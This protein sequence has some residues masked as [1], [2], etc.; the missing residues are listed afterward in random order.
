M[1]EINV[2]K[3]LKLD[4]Q[5]DRPHSRSSADSCSVRGTGSRSGSRERN[6]R[7]K[8]ESESREPTNR[9]S[10]N[11]F[12]EKCD[13]YRD[14]REEMEI[15]DTSKTAGGV[16]NERIDTKK[17][18]GSR[19][20]FDQ[21][22]DEW[23]NRDRFCSYRDDR[24]NNS[25]GR[26]SDRNRMGHDGYRK[27]SD[28]E[29]R[30][31]DR[32]DAE[33][34]VEDY[35]NFNAVYGRDVRPI[36]RHNYGGRDLPPS[37]S[38]ERSNEADEKFER[39]R[40]PQDRHD[41]RER[42][43]RPDRRER[44]GSN[45]NI[46]E[47]C[48]GNHVENEIS[49]H[50]K[51]L[52]T[53]LITGSDD[54]SRNK[55]VKKK[56]KMLQAMEEKM[57]RKRSSLGNQ[58]AKDQSHKA[59]VVDLTDFAKD[60]NGMSEKKRIVGATSKSGQKTR[61]S[62][63]IPK[64]M[65]SNLSEENIKS[66]I[67]LTEPQHKC[68]DR[69]D[70]EEDSEPVRRQT[71]HGTPAKQAKTCED[72]EIMTRKPEERDK[73]TLERK[74]LEF[75]RSLQGGE[76]SKEE[77]DEDKNGCNKEDK[78]EESVEDKRQR[79]S[80]RVNRQSDLDSGNSGK[81][82]EPQKAKESAKENSKMTPVS[83]S[84]KKIVGNTNDKEVLSSSV[85]DKD[86]ENAKKDGTIVSDSSA[87]ILK[88][89]SK[90]KGKEN[91]KSKTEDL[92]KE[93]Q[94]EEPKKS[95]QQEAPDV[96]PEVNLQIPPTDPQ[97]EKSETNDENVDPKVC[98]STA[99]QMDGGAKR[100]SRE[101]LESTTCESGADATICTADKSEKNMCH[102][103]IRDEAVKKCDETAKDAPITPVEDVQ[104]E[105]EG[106]GGS[107]S[108]SSAKPDEQSSEETLEKNKRNDETK[109]KIKQ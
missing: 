68:N 73:E 37:R 84:D 104:R 77:T 109:R 3:R 95:A 26:Y 58:N 2:H 8:A 25:R 75:K 107:A 9:E 53:N 1:P 92:Q 64:K 69:R 54:G 87:K 76:E 81:V 80:S 89:T 21:Y 12:P 35:F 102:Q 43:Q 4:N 62:P 22:D 96:N 106:D 99:N 45:S 28:R 29:N 32:Y 41:G 57:K 40:T 90:K 88:E 27:S 51:R 18:G 105:I 49:E 72:L 20:R 34:Q 6:E 67:D 61:D 94:S 38:R 15:R 65:S 71:K 93:V 79:K 100:N 17:D 78:V 31:D 36:E 70:K 98:E 5:E 47:K 30:F 44:T 97:I 39:S 16:E 59:D 24:R 56:L 101:K 50:E 46:D 82:G 74:L 19:E 108:K 48:R 86:K 14:D 33:K 23:G 60:D 63:R 55:P 83:R 10:R 7:H 42:T 13:E 85:A 52:S 66:V 11:Q 103:K 91:P